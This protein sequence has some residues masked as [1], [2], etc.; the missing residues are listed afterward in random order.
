MHVIMAN[1]RDASSGLDVSKPRF[2]F[3]GTAE[4]AT[5]LAQR[6]TRVSSTS[7]MLSQLQPQWHSPDHPQWV[8]AGLAVMRTLD[9]NVQIHTY[10]TAEPVGMFVEPGPPVTDNPIEQWF[11]YLRGGI[12]A[13][14]LP[15]PEEPPP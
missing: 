14:A 7:H 13:P 10:Y 6:L 12:T 5:A 1:Y 8:E 3:D 9:P 11:Y 15:P 4:D 2:L